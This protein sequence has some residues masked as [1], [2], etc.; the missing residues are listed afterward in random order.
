MSATTITAPKLSTI[1][2]IVSDD[3]SSTNSLPSP[4]EKEVTI[5]D[6]PPPPSTN[7]EVHTKVQLNDEFNSCDALE[8]F[9]LIIERSPA[10]D[11]DDI[12]QI[13]EEIS[14][15]NRRI[16]KLRQLCNSQ[17]PYSDSVLWMNRK[18]AQRLKVLKECEN[19]V[20]FKH[21]RFSKLGAYFVQKQVGLKK[22]LETLTAC[23]KNAATKTNT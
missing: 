16:L 9:K 17:R 13:D 21:A 7:T 8:R 5:E 15:S 3:S 4:Q 23:A 11:G 12:K 22:D 2:E 18:V 14:R 1:T 20:D 19:V 10:F 6:H